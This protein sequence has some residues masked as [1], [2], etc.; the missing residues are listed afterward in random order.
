M[1]YTLRS[2]FTQY[3][4]DSGSKV[5]LIDGQRRVTYQQLIEKVHAQS[6][7]LQSL[8]IQKGDRVAIFLSRSVESVVAL[9]AVWFVG[10]V[11]VFVNDA[12][13]TRQVNYILEHAEVSLLIT[14]SGL[15]TSLDYVALP[16]A[17]IITLDDEFPDGTHVASPTLIGD[18]LAMI[19]YTS[20]STGLPKGIMLSHQNLLS[21][22]SIVSEYLGLTSDDVLI[23][24]LPFSF[25]YGLN[26]LLTSMLVG[27]TLVLQ[28]SLFPADICSTLL[29]EHVTGMAGVPML[30]QQLAHPRSPFTKTRFPKLRYMTNTGG[31]MPENITKLFR[32]SHPDAKIFLMYGLTEAFRS[33]HLPPDQ[34]DKRPTSVGKAIP[35]VELIVINGEGKPCK[36]G[37]PGELIHR[38]ANI[39]LGYWKDPETTARVFRPNPFVRPDGGRPEIVVYS[40]D[41]FKTDDEGFLYFIGR[42]DAMIKSR[43]MRVSPDEI[44]ECIHGSNLVSHVV[45]FA[46]DK[47]EAENE[48][49]VAVVP[50][51]PDSFKEQTLH[52]YCKK[53][54]P[55][56]HRPQVVWIKQALPQTSSGKPDR[57]LIKESYLRDVVGASG[58]G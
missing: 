43:G 38:G 26:Q 53:E 27:G 18:D 24:L 28:H 29:R 12:L 7:V 36:P 20:G 11:A 16:R 21:G 52:L 4:T 55:E 42:R 33:A 56:F 32:Q 41:T 37:E 22:A 3:Q 54:M 30:W 19:I 50:R 9:F 8:G 31:R 47:N 57:V 40:G 14:S 46:V 35:N 44:E 34:V 48:I 17:R 6:S 58:G 49:V 39:S 1:L 25:D 45:A 15:L 5:A 13:K 23:S 51:D 10:A 2:F